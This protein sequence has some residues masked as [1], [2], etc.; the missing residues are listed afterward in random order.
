MPTVASL[1][2]GAGGMDL[3]FKSA[4]FEIVYANDFDK[5]ACATYRENIGDHIVEA[6]IED[7][8]VSTIPDCDVM[9][10]G[11]PCQGFSVAGKMSLEDERSQL[12]YNFADIVLE[13][14]PRA[15]VMENVDHLGKSPRFKLTRDSLREL[16]ETDYFV[17]DGILV[18]SD[19]GVPQRRRRYFMVGLLKTE[20]ENQSTEPFLPIP[21]GKIAPTSRDILLSFP[22]P[23]Q[24]GNERTINAKI[25]LAASPVMRKSPYSGMLFNGLGRPVDLN[26]PIQTLAATFGGNKTPVVDERELRNGEDPWIVDYHSKLN[27]G[28]QAVFKEGPDFLRRLTVDECIVFQDFPRNYVLH[29][30]K[31][32]MFRQIGNAVPPGLAR[33][34]AKQIL[35]ILESL[36]IVLDLVA[37]VKP[38]HRSPNKKFRRGRA[39]SLAELKAA[40]IELWQAKK[41][42][43]RID[44]RRKSEH[45]ENVDLLR[46]LQTS[47]HN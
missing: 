41:K 35:K 11:P 5:H 37:M 9:I 44:K 30:P 21:N 4:G 46:K 47:T 16:F 15:F 43:V 42:G 27:N 7:I 18:A 8:D 6:S 36:K 13:K 23:G 26:R 24:E 28:M 3:G 38:Q 25:T 34:I 14:K 17:Q 31:S 20:I 2:S 32:A 10:G 45:K 19:F 1:F 22:P 33:V 29:G 39:F 12:V 40:G